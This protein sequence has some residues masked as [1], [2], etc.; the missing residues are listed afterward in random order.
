MNNNILTSQEHKIFGSSNS[1]EKYENNPYTPL[2]IL[3]GRMSV[4]ECNRGRI[5]K[6]TLENIA[7]S[8]WGIKYIKCEMSLEPLNLNE[9]SKE[10]GQTMQDP[11]LTSISIP[12]DIVPI[13]KNK[14]PNARQEPKVE[15]KNE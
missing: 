2:A 14:F 12:M 3:D 8:F 4:E 9:D 6:G 11:I 1:G 10:Y 13:F 5:E 15:L 7:G